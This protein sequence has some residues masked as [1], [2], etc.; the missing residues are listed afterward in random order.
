MQRVQGLEDQMFVDDATRAVIVTATFYNRN[1]QMWAW[2]KLVFE[3][4]AG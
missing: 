2:V 3:F 1:F 4:S